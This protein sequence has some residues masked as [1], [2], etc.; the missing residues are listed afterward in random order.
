MTSAASPTTMRQRTSLTRS[1]TLYTAKLAS[2]DKP[3][4]GP[5][6]TKVE[7]VTSAAPTGLSMINGSLYAGSH[8]DW[9][10]FGITPSSGKRML[11]L[12]TEG[13][14]DPPFLFNGKLCFTT[15]S[16][17]L[18][19]MPTG[20]ISVT[21]EALQKMVKS[22]RVDTTSTLT[23]PW[24]ACHL[25]ERYVLLRKRER[26]VLRERRHNGDHLEEHR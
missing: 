23:P 2:F 16:G 25:R 3:W 19:Q 9:R 6:N 7:N 5:N 24:L 1:G 17:F 8:Q 21:R 15:S 14:A 22:V 12:D 20:T 18:Y 11:E 4:T 10:L 13:W 26:C